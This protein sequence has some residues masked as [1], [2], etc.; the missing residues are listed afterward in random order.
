MKDWVKY[1]ALFYSI[2]LEITLFTG[3]GLGAGY[4]MYKKGIMPFE[5]TVFTSLVGFSVSVYRLYLLSKKTG[6]PE[7]GKK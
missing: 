6:E 7:G 4:F 5:V 2:V 3:L 1:I